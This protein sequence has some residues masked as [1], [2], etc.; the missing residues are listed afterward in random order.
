VD[1]KEASG[2]VGSTREIEHQHDSEVGWRLGLGS[3][4]AKIPH[5]GLPIYRGFDIHT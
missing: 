4:F 1:L 2:M 3:I 5:E